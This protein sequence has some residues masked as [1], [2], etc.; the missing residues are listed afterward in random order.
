MIDPV[1]PMPTIWRDEMTAWRWSRTIGRLR[2]LWRAAT[3]DDQRHH[4]ERLIEDVIADGE[5]LHR[6]GIT[7]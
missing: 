6:R 1:P 2:D 3:T 4:I 7:L 5:E